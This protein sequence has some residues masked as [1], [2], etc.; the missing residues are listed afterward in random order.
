MAGRANWIDAGFAAALTALLAMSTACGS[1]QPPS[2]GGAQPSESLPSGARADASPGDTTSPEGRCSW[3]VPALEPTIKPAGNFAVQ[4]NDLDA[5]ASTS[6]FPNGV[7]AP[8]RDTLTIDG[9]GTEYFVAGIP[10]QEPS[11]SPGTTRGTA[12]ARAGRAVEAFDAVSGEMK[13]QARLPGQVSGIVAAGSGVVVVYDED[14]TDAVAAY[15]DGNRLWSRAKPANLQPVHGGRTVLV[16]SDD[17]KVEAID[18]V[19]GTSCWTYET[20]NG[21]ELYNFYASPKGVLVNLWPGTGDGATKSVVVDATGRVSDSPCPTSEVYSAVGTT[22]VCIEIGKANLTPFDVDTL[23]AGKTVPFLVNF[24]EGRRIAGGDNLIVTM[25]SSGSST[26][27]TA[28]DHSG[29]KRWSKSV[30][31]SSDSLG[32]AARSDVVT[33]S[34]P[35]HL[36]ILSAK[37]GSV[38]SDDGKGSFEVIAPVDSAGIFVRAASSGQFT[39]GTTRGNPKCGLAVLDT[40][41]GKLDTVPGLESFGCTSPFVALPRAVATN[42]AV[43]RG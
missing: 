22:G 20:P 8:T 35:D 41:T 30:S 25:E 34:S 39:S 10:S 19:D 33:V 36:T 7:V 26:M 23:T 17:T 40:G 21:F 11:T 1:S 18:A 32:A 38:V 2:T 27:V 43:V 16:A 12:A 31:V 5:R 4:L 37:D 14:G 15:K 24:E 6:S 9:D 3:A 28:Y 42:S 29:E 13:W